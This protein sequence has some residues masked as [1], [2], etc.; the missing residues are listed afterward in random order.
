MK[1]V[2]GLYSFPVYDSILPSIALRSSCGWGSGV[3]LMARSKADDV[4]WAIRNPCRYLTACPLHSCKERGLQLLQHT[5]YNWECFSRTIATVKSAFAPSGERR[6]DILHSIHI[7]TYLV[8]ISQD[9]SSVQH[10]RDDGGQSI[11]VTEHKFIRFND[12]GAGRRHA[13]TVDKNNLHGTRRSM[14]DTP[15]SDKEKQNRA[16]APGYCC[17][18]SGL[19]TRY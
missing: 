17:T 3:T 2:V 19:R 10:G 11:F 16:R 7:I 4:S 1:L 8:Y 9:S 5:D 18:R 13:L 6:K 12:P 14:T 15:S